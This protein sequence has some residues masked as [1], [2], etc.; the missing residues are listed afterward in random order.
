M[1]DLSRSR[2]LS[3]LLWG[4]LILGVLGPS[5]LDP[6]IDKIPYPNEIPCFDEIP[7]VDDIPCVYNIP[8]VDE[9]PCVVPKFGVFECVWW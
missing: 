4:F 1:N 6:C 2:K 3:N 7:C 5:R 8:C 9:V